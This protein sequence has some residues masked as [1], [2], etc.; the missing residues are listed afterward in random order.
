MNINKNLYIIFSLF[1]FANSYSF[2]ND[3]QVSN[4][5]ELINSNPQSG[6]VI[7]FTNN[8]YSLDSIG[9]NFFNLNLT[10]DGN[11]YYLN[12]AN[13]YGG[14]ILNQDSL[15]NNIKFQN[16]KGQEYNG[17]D[18]AGAVFNFN[19]DI[20][21]ENSG[22]SGNFAEA[23]G[24]DY[25][26]GGA[27]YNL[28]QGSITIDSTSFNDNYA[29]GALGAGGAIANG[30]S[31]SEHPVLSVNNTTFENNFASGAV[32]VEGGAIY[33]HGTAFINNS[34]FRNNYIQSENEPISF[35]EGGA[36]SNVGT[37]TINNSLFTGN[38]SKGNGSQPAVLGGAVYNSG[39]LSINNSTFSGNYVDSPFYADGGAIY[40]DS[41]GLLTLSNSLIENNSVSSQSQFAAGGAV[42]N[43]GRLIVEGGTFKSNFDKDG[44]LNDIFNTSTGTVEFTS[45][46]VTNI[47]SGIKGSGNIIKDG[48]GVLNLGG[49]NFQYTGNFKFNSGTLNLLAHSSY[50]SASDT[51]LGGGTNFNMQNG[52][53]ED[54]NFGNLNITGSSNFFVDVN[55]NNN[56]M[57]RINANSVSGAGAIDVKN[58]SLQ[59]VPE[60]EFIS[61]PFADSMLKD[62]VAYAPSIIH[63]PIYNYNAGYDSGN[64]NF[65]FI[66][67][68]FN[69]SVFVPAVAAQLAGYATQ[70]ET[71]KNVFSNLDMVMITPPGQRKSY[72]FKNKIASTANQFTFSPLYF[73]EERVGI[74]FKPYT[75]FEK[76][77]LKHGPDVSNVSYGSLFGCENGLV[78]LKKGWYNLSG[79]YASYNGSHQAFNGNSI[80]NNGGLLGLDTAFY[81]GNFFSLWT[82]NVG[83]S[84]AEAHT[85]FGKDNFAMLN[86]GIAEK[87]GYNFETLENRL[88]IQPSLLMSYTFVNTFNYTSNA[89]VHMESDPLHAIHIEPQIKL[90]GNFKNY[91]QPYI[92]VSMIWNILDD[93][94]FQA[95]DVY[96][97]ELSVKPYVQY[98]IGVQ[99]RWGE[100]VTG[101]LESMIRNG[102]RNGVALQFG[103]RFSI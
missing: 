88:I 21:I 65:N 47:E 48:S 1:C 43:A 89:G 26:I 19:G 12:G 85:M 49:Q 52:Q 98:G 17:S 5:E 96:L 32:T 45:S 84:S 80:Y 103:I 87:T 73:P 92:S 22:F 76:V 42:Y 8:L 7:E 41:T 74:W 46:S 67:D 6:D 14:F 37:M 61:I 24:T 56:T 23:N 9:Q 11:N 81:K 60:G 62:S 39:N 25:A 38:Y 35:L 40:N 91:L 97:P 16:C 33:N 79:I 63:T 55:F 68:G 2:A 95:N 102:G 29:H 71:Y 10:F 70:I 86:T 57:D 31:Q 50:F 83:A 75:V 30:F 101:F 77:Q 36:I 94:K 44:E 51:T 78:K 69:P 3:I 66:R 82:A 54:I 18:F 59:G 15:F 53:V 28:N 20:S 4:F 93:T 13:T 64:G 27:V 72:A 90:I 58:L 100:R 99:K 34:T